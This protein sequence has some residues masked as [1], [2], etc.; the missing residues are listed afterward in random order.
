MRSPEQAQ[1]PQ[2][3]SGSARAK[4]AQPRDACGVFG[5]SGIGSDAP[6]Q[7]GMRGELSRHPSCEA[8]RDGGDAKGSTAHDGPDGEADR[9]YRLR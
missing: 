3:L 9:N 7:R 4:V 5:L 8:D 6:W 1:D 2:D